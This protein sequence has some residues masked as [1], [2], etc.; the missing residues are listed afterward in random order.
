VL[1][2]AKRVLSLVPSPF[3]AEM[4]ASEM[5]AA[6]NPDS[7]AVAPDSFV[8]NFIQMLF[9]ITVLP[10]A[11]PNARNRFR[12]ARAKARSSVLNMLDG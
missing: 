8:Q 3:T 10:N 1:I 2:E 4:I 11:E 6:I 9:I 12:K 7:M 5:S